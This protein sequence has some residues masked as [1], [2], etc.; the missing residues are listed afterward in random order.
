[1]CQNS[2]NSGAEVAE[3]IKEPLRN[4][5]SLCQRPSF[6]VGALSRVP[7]SLPAQNGTWTDNN[8]SIKGMHEFRLYLC[9]FSLLAP[10]TSEPMRRICPDKHVSMRVHIHGAK[11]RKV[12]V[13]AA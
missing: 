9:A 7:E 10:I 11:V 5:T 6:P 13:I 12:S 1:M 3:R 2:A 4:V 8:G